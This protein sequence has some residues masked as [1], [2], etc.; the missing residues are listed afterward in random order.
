[1]PRPTTRVLRP[2]LAA[3]LALLAAC[4]SAPRATV[5]Q[6]PIDLP[7][8]MGTWYVIGH[9]PYFSERGHVEGRHQY[10]LLDGG[11]VQVQYLYRT[12]FQQPQ[13]MLA[14]TATVEPDS[15]NRV[16]RLRFFRVVPAA[17]RILEVAP[18][19]AWALLDSPGRELAWVFAR[20]PT[21]DDALYLELLA[22]L[23]AHGINSDKVWRMPQDPS[24]VGRLGFERP[25]DP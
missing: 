8:F 25:N 17:Q 3:T 4:A 2:F 24:Q 1:M 7:A 20:Q 16:W 12:G 21:M 13:K 5:P 14:A 23:R 6:T 10:T 18:D 9:I 15:G 19:G 22:R 11:Q